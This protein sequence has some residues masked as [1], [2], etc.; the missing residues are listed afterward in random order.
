MNHYDDVCCLITGQ[1]PGKGSYLC[2]NCNIVVDIDQEYEKLPTCPCCEQQVFYPHA[3]SVHS[4]GT[5]TDPT[6]LTL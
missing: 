3:S 1:E 6:L 5:F 4:I 2:K